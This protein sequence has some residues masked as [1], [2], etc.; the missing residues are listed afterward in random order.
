MN[1]KKKQEN[2]NFEKIK[3]QTTSKKDEHIK[4][5][6][7]DKKDI[8]KLILKINNTNNIKELTSYIKFDVDKIIINKIMNLLANK[9]DRTLK[10]I[11]IEINEFKNSRNRQINTIEEEFFLKRKNIFSTLLVIFDTLSIIKKNIFNHLDKN[12][13]DSKNYLYVVQNAIDLFFDDFI[14]FFNNFNINMINIELNK[15]IYDSKLHQVIS[16]NEDKKIKNNV[17]IA[18]LKK[19]FMFK[20]IALRKSLVIVNKN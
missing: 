18:E 5:N 13:Y 11:Q 1:D 2:K 19:G 17:I 9:Y 16:F 8:D 12:K 3:N 6:N 10:E 14:T 15:T 4:D 20:E 7:N